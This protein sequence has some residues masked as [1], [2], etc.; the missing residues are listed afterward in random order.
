MNPKPGLRRDRP[1]IVLL[2]RLAAA[3]TVCIALLPAT[4]QAQLDWQPE[5]TWL[6]AVGILQWEHADVWPGMP[7]AKT[8]RRDVE[9]VEHFRSRGVPGKQ[10]V[11]LQDGKATRQRIQHALTE[12][13]AQTRKGDF[14]IFYYTG[15]GSRN[16]ETHQACFANYDA[17]D[18]DG[19]WQVSAIFDTIEQHFHGEKALLI[20][21]CCFSGALVDV[22]RQRETKISYGCLCSSFSHNTST[23]NW[24]FTESLLKGWRGDPAVDLDGNRTIE[25]E[26]MGRSAELD[27]AFIERQKSMFQTTS[28]FDRHMKLAAANG[29]RRPRLGERL[30]A[31][32]QGNWYRAQVIDVRD[33]QL[34]IHYVGDADSWD[35]WVGPE[36]IRPFRPHQFEVGQKVDVQ[37]NADKKWYP[38]TVVRPWY[39]LHLVSY[40]HYS[41]EWNEWVAP[42][43][44]RP[45]Q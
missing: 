22:A 13:L 42:E 45:R 24:T 20:A 12:H 44:I 7:G 37:W 5:R 40:D 8:D 18:S 19:A 26:E 34:K 29:P 1:R 36:R 35:E 3:L 11:Y 30:E 23:G 14:L 38:A 2:P 33:K 6:F 4:S 21:D 41:R 25:W 32:W 15:H 10:I 43:S 28:G 39:G 17:A 27:M 9:L 16:H 31:K